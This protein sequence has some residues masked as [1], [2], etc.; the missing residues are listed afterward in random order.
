MEVVIVNSTILFYIHKNP[1]DIRYYYILFNYLID[2]NKIF[3]FL[4]G[5]LDNKHEAWYESASCR[6][7]VRKRTCDRG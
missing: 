4:P 7:F 6:R 3:C 1:V 2:K 5:G